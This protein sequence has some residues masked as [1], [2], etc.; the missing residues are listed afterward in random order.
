MRLISGLA[1]AL[2]ISSAGCVNIPDDSLQSA[3]Q[4]P[5]TTLSR[6]V[7]ITARVSAGGYLTQAVIKPWGRQDIKVLLIKVYTLDGTSEIPLRL[8]DGKANEPYVIRVDSDL[9]DDAIEVRNLA[10]NTTYRLRAQAFQAADEN[11]ASLISDDESSWVDIVVK[12][13]DRPLAATLPIQLIDRLFSGEATQSL[14][15]KPGTVIDDATQSIDLI[16]PASVNQQ[17]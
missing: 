7:T 12:N 3:L 11:D 14:D 16:E 1:L 2:A 17:G 15:V 4:K 9:L 8:G 6:T 5:G 13:D 10:P